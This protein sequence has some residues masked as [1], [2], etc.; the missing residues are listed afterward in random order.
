MDPDHSA[1]RFYRKVTD[2]LFPVNQDA[3]RQASCAAESGHTADDVQ[4]PD[5]ECREEF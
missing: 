5:H 1:L 2:A 4:G 3:T